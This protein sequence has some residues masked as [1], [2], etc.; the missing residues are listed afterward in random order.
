MKLAKAH[1]I[2]LYY[3][4]YYYICNQPMGYLP[5]NEQLNSTQSKNL[6]I[7]LEWDCGIRHVLYV[8]PVT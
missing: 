5:D 8:I 3:I 7:K 2:I 6:N 1:T 4:L